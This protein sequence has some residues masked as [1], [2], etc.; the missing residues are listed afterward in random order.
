MMWRS[1]FAALALLCAGAAFAQ[2]VVVEGDV[3][4]RQSF[5]ADS[6]K[7]FDA[8]AQT[9]YTVSR[10]VDGRKQDT[11]LRGVRLA[12][13]LER[14]G[15]AERDR[16]DWRK[17]VVLV[18][19]RDGYRVA[20]SWPELFNTEGG[21]QVLVAFERDGSPLADEEGPL[22]LVAPADVRSGP[23]RVKWLHRVEVRILRE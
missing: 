23:R 11:V 7:R 21:A 15:L 17:A 12:A 6:L 2:G 13:L 18:S 3:K 4:Q 9:R 19:A 1:S 10:E 16:L 5:D 8:A 14:A 20:F 22:A